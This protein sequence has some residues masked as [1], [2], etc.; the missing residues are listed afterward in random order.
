MLHTICLCKN[1]LFYLL[2][3]ILPHTHEVEC[4]SIWKY[5][6]PSV[7][8]VIQLPSVVVKDFIYYLGFEYNCNNVY[9]FAQYNLIDMY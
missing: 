9:Y 7:T 2:N 8:P 6:R 1:K 4:M 5:C 3:E